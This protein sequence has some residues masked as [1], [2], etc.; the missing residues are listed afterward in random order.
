MKLGSLASSPSRACA[1]VD[2]VQVDEFAL[3]ATQP[4]DSE[5]TQGVCDSHRRYVSATPVPP[6]GTTEHQAQ[7]LFHSAV[8]AV[9]QR[10]QKATRGG[11]VSH[12]GV[13]DDALWITAQ[14]LVS[15]VDTD[16][17]VS[18]A[19]LRQMEKQRLVGPNVGRRGPCVVAVGVSSCAMA[20]REV[21]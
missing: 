14:Q 6:A 3:T 21:L 8:V 19:I 10:A 4:S 13:D 15:L 1:C 18:R 20:Y 17:E 16:L 7:L 12:V 2:A 11:S 9:M 5:A